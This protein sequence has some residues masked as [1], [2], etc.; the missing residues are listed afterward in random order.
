MCAAVAAIDNVSVSRLKYSHTGCM[1][2]REWA[3][4]G[5]T[6]PDRPKYSGRRLFKI[7]SWSSAH[8]NGAY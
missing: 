5:G 2:W 4:T 8:A 7:K 6:P 1:G 3:S